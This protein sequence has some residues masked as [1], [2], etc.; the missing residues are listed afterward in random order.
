MFLELDK[1]IRTQLRTSLINASASGHEPDEL[2]YTRVPEEL[3]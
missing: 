1:G 3:A 2:V